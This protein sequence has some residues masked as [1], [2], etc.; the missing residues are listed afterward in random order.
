[1]ST[2]RSSQS[3]RASSKPTLKQRL[4]EAQ[5]Q[6]EA[7]ERALADA[8]EQLT[9]QQQAFDQLQE[10]HQVLQ[11]ELSRRPLPAS[12]AEAPE[13]PGSKSSFRIDLY[14]QDDQALQG[15]IEHMLSQE[16]QTFQG[17]SAHSLIEFIKAHLPQP[18]PASPSPQA[19]PPRG[20]EARGR[21][22]PPA[23]GRV[24]LKTMQLQWAAKGDATTSASHDRPF[25]VHLEVDPARSPYA[26]SAWVYA[27]AVSGRQYLLG[28][29]PSP[30]VNVSSHSLSVK[31]GILKPGAYRLEAVLY[32]S[33]AGSPQGTLGDSRLGSWV[34]LL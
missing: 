30:L 34:Q 14:V 2:P 18:E 23:F 10:A 27:R 1:M 15:K 11:D 4:A 31:A 28:K 9:K 17:L 8:Y 3:S 19:A 21:E 16:K 24:Q 22:I 25:W 32:H 7:R 29:T 20:G 13:I 5:E 6:L 26:W 33:Q 12:A